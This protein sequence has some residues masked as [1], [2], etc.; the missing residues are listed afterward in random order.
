MLKEQSSG[1]A[2]WICNSACVEALITIALITNLPFEGFNSSQ[3]TSHKYPT[4]GIYVSG[5]SYS[6]ENTKLHSRIFGKFPESVF[7]C[8]LWELSSTDWVMQGCLIN[9][10]TKVFL[11][12]L[13]KETALF[14]LAFI[15]NVLPLMIM[16]LIDRDIEKVK[17]T[18]WI[19][20]YMQGVSWWDNSNHLIWIFASF[21][22]W[23]M[24][25]FIMPS[26]LRS[27]I[28]IQNML[29]QETLGER[30]LYHLTLHPIFRSG[31]FVIVKVRGK[32]LCSAMHYLPNI[33]HVYTFRRFWSQ[34]LA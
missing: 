4:A 2:I 21:K 9:S 25:P 3:S 29:W 5:K 17:T 8:E 18:F 32:I 31:L 7:P 16:Q 26:L 33:Y 22:F 12:K 23:I 19:S 28:L 20:R 10:D 24:A 13:W 11:E 34:E 15:I 6:A 1:I 14:S 27:F 30:I